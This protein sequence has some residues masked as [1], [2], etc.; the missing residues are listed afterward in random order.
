[1][2]ALPILGVGTADV[3][4]RTFQLSPEQK[5]TRT[6]GAADAA[7]SDTGSTWV[8]QMP[9]SGGFSESSNDVR[10]GAAP[11]PA[12]VLPRGSRVLEAYSGFGTLSHAD[13]SVQTSFTDLA[14]DDPLAKGLYRTVAGNRATRRDE[15]VL[16]TELA[17]R[18]G[19]ATGDTVT[20]D[21]SPVTVTGIVDSTSKKH[22]VDALVA[23]GTVGR[24]QIAQILVDVPGSLTWADVRRANAHGFLLTP[25]G[26]VPGEPPAMALPGPIGAKTLTFVGLIAGMVLIEIVL[27][28]GPA[29]AVGVKR[30]SR[31][32]ALVAATGGDR[33]HLRTVVL[34]GGVVLGAVGGAA[35][36][37]VGIAAAWFVVPLFTEVQDTRPGPFEVRPVE[38]L[39][40]VGVG[41]VTAL[42]AAMLPARAAARTDVLAALTGRR[43]SARTR[44]R[45]PILG[46]MGTVAGAALA[47]Y[48]ARKLNTNIVL[49]GSIVAELGLVAT[50]PF[51]VGL[52]ARLGRFLP[53]G[54]RFALRDAARNRGRTAPAVSAILAAVA[55]TIAVSTFVG[56][57]D[58]HQHNQ[59]QT[60]APAGAAVV[61]L[62]Y[63]GSPHTREVAAA[64]ARTLP[65]TTVTTVRGLG[66]SSGPAV[67]SASIEENQL[68]RCPS[69]RY[70]SRAALKVLA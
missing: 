20:R 17:H 62:R 67:M 3:L 57:Q 24:K 16:T 63:S 32:L 25:R 51:L 56:S 12:S 26:R 59:Y 6:M 34:G 30:R 35:G 15:V 5:A 68:R 9:G 1:M 4:Y 60:Q 14:Y 69:Q 46:A 58:A 40:I 13:V 42:L 31:D 41:V 48:G 21:G 44:K 19:I 52:V 2:I 54:P 47:L 7:L 18:L 61:D 39:A 65:G 8:R 28:A 45:G 36:A 38:M 49:A 66:F 29:F 22:A 43:G 33:G 50:T 11:S 37:A 64:L 70:L 55:G 23:P 53:V 10:T 27:L